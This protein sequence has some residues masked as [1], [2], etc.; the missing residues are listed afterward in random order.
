MFEQHKPI[1]GLFYLATLVF[2]G[3]SV[4]LLYLDADGIQPV[5]YWYTCFIICWLMIFLALIMV[6]YH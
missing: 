4:Y 3:L 5:N 1:N 6:N 2:Y